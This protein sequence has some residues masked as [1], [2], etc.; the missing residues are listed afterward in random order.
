MTKSWSTLPLVLAIG[1]AFA[2]PGVAQEA[3]DTTEVVPLQP[4]VVNVLRTPFEVSAAPFAVAA[5]TEAEVQLA[6]PGLGM[7]EA[8]GGIPGVQVDDRYNYALG[9]RI[10]IRG[11][12]ARTPFGVRGVSVLV[13]GIPATLPDGT[14]NLNHVDLSFLR[15]VEVIR[16]PA[17]SLY[18]NAAGGVIHFETETPPAVPLSEEVGFTAGSNGLL[19][20]HSTTG[21]QSNG[22]TYNLN[23]QRLTYDGYRTFQEAE[24]VQVNGSFGTRA[25]GGDVR[26]VASFVDYDANNPGSLNADDFAEDP[27]QAAFINQQDQTGEEGR[28]GQVGA[29][30]RG[31]LGLG[32]L[33]LAGYGLTREIS[34]PIPGTLIDIERV[35]GGLSALYRSSAEPAQTGFHWAFGVDGDLQSDDRL[36]FEIND[37]EPQ[38]DPFI[39]QDEQV[40]SGAAFAQA[41]LV[42]VEGLTALA[43]LRYDVTRFEATDRLTADNSGDRTMDA[44][45]PSIG[46]TYEA[47]DAI[48]VYG[49]VA[50]SFETPT[51]TELA[52]QPSGEGGFNEDLEPQTTV[53]FEAGVKGL[54]PG[55]VT[56]QLSL[57]RANVEDALIPFTLGDERTYFRNA[58]S[59]IHQGV[60]AG[61]TV[62]PFEGVRANVAYTYLDARFDDYLVDGESL[63]DNRIPGV[64]PHR[65][66]GSVTYTAPIGVYATAEARYAD[67]MP[68]NDVNTANASAYTVV[69]FRTGLEALDLGGL[70]I[71]PFVGVTNIFD[72]VYVTSP[73]LNHLF[74]RYYEPGPGRAFYAGAQLRIN[75][76]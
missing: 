65:L 21:G 74:G 56:Y 37:G 4:V 61:L 52:N 62:A 43:G 6:R 70:A 17:S 45:S 68:V 75:V 16:G 66:D 23:V 18:G 12:G 8:L 42:P 33:E 63:G 14:T 11:F 25:A 57:F 36:N 67:T 26:V 71:E 76:D 48:S 49:N 27:T 58:G 73:S 5:N 30:W 9:D 1:G 59:A 3:P 47:S 41:T 13:D 24:N 20:F 32:Q 60:E 39:S 29:S 51:A 38:T 31:A 34:N 19:R 15:R 64:N 22:A 10:S 46:L 2:A 44:F 69:D 72:E 35:G 53:S 50:T 54:L 40:I 55:L 28:Q 7:E